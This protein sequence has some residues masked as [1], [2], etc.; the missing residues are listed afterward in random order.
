[1]D[2]DGYISVLETGL[3]PYVQNSSGPVRFMQDN[4]PKH[5]S[6][7]AREWMEKEE[8]NWWK[9]PAESPDLNPSERNTAVLGDCYHFKV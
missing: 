5:T 7:K 6:R 1:M 3:K 2:A 4:D 8:I 9:T